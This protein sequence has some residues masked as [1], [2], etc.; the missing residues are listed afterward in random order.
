MARVMNTAARMSLLLSLCMMACDTDP[1]DP[2]PSK[3][4]AGDPVPELTIEDPPGFIDDP[5]ELGVDPAVAAKAKVLW[6]THCARCHGPSGDGKGSDGEALDPAPRN[7]HRHA[8][9]ASAADEHIKKVI[10]EGGAAS[11]LSP[12]MAANVDLQGQPELVEQMVLLLRGFPH[13]K[14]TTDQAK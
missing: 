4:I 12:A 3:A 7:F 5:A 13:W 1:R 6:D 14:P 11:G 8:W 10:L 2:Q 9:Q